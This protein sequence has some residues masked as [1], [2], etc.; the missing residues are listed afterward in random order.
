[1]DKSLGRL[2]TG[3]QNSNLENGVRVQMDEFNL[4]MINVSMEKVTGEEA[5]SALEEGREHHNLNCIG[6]RNVF[7]GGRMPLQDGAVREKVIHN[8]LADFAFIRDRWLEKMRV[9]GGHHGEEIFQQHGIGASAK[10][11]IARNGDGG[12]RD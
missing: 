6:C 5:K 7:P 9:R 3:G 12:R 4:V 10:E 2:H 11:E 8:K 1:L